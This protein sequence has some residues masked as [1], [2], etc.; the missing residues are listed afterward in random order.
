MPDYYHVE[1]R[2]KAKSRG[3]RIFIANKYTISVNF[4]QMKKIAS[5]PLLIPL[6]ALRALR[7]THIGCPFCCNVIALDV[8]QVESSTEALS[9]KFPTYPYSSLF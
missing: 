9:L 4:F 8:L 6:G 5:L 7:V 3:L 1:F 2:P